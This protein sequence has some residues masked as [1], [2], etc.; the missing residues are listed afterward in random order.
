MATLVYIVVYIAAMGYLLTRPEE[1]RAGR[2][3]RV[4]VSLGA[5]GGAAYLGWRMI[6]SYGAVPGSLAWT[7]IFLCAARVLA[8]I[9]APVIA[10]QMGVIVANLVMPFELLA[11]TPGGF[12]PDFRTALSCLN[13]EDWAQARRSVREEMRKDPQSYEGHILM[14]CIGQQ[15]GHRLRARRHIRRILKNPAST[16]EQKRFARQFQTAYL[17]SACWLN[18]FNR[19]WSRRALPLANGLISA[20]PLA[21]NFVDEP[22]PLLSATDAAGDKTR[23]LAFLANTGNVAGLLTLAASKEF[24]L[25][26]YQQAQVVVRELARHGDPAK[27]EVILRK[28]GPALFLSELLTETLAHV[29]PTDRPM[30]RCL[31]DHGASAALACRKLR[32][33]REPSPEDSARRQA[34][35]EEIERVHLSAQP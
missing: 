6:Q 22:A 4:G 29:T 26:A 9:W 5:T 18:L 27:L 34:L 20:M 17:T 32:A 30:I 2:W 10:H 24:D 21:T 1:L 16:A 11:N 23:R 19:G 8:F 13:S 35:A 12:R 28:I 3:L 31:L 14:A 33:R 7:F 25:L 15:T